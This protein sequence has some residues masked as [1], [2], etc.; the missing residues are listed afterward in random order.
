MQNKILSLILLSYYSGQRIP[1]AFYKIKELLDRENIPFEF[2][3]MDD[4]SKDDSYKIALDLEKN[5]P[6]VKA[7]QLSKN[8]TSHYSIFAGLTLCNGACAMP[9]VD[10]EQQPYSTI[11]E[12]YRLW[13]KG[14]KVIIPHRVT[15][16]DSWSSRFLSETYYKI[17]N[18]LSE[19]SFPIGGADL[20][21]IDRELIDL[22]ANK[23]HH[24]KTSSII[25]V[26][27]LGFDPIYLP[28]NRPLGLNEGKSRWSF[29]KKVNLA[30]DTFFTSSTFPIRLILNLGL[31]FSFFSFFLICFY[32]YIYFFGNNSF[33]KNTLP[34]WTSLVVFISFFSGLILFSIG[35]LAEYIWRIYEEVKARPGFIVKK[36]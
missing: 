29:R 6:N 5:E 22:L 1:T 27:R 18:S 7:Y 28:Y 9:M 8:Y 30:K 25:E 36:K 3:V 24:I 12:M 31:F 35:V 23:I 10:D 26:L 19:V 13:E 2:I 17:M 33:W 20:Y 16:D 21:F 11:V 32:I 15:R 34:G 4:G 14:A